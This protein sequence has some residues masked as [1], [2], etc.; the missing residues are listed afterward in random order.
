MKIIVNLLVSVIAIFVAAYLLPGVHIASWQT[1]I[2]LA[3]VLGAINIFIRPVLSLLTLPLSILTL[4][5]F[6]VVLNA[7]LILLASKIVPGFT[8]DSFLT[9]VLFGFVLGV[10][11][12][13]LK[14]FAK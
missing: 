6:S 11:H 13:V 12:F 2:I 3:V 1:Y 4:G 9:A 10:V 8:I 14:M 7:L 5:L